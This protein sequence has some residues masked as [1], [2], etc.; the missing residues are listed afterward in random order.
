MSFKKQ[1]L[2]C[3]WAPL[4]LED[5]TMEHVAPVVIKSWVLS[6]LPS[7]MVM[8]THQNPLQDKVIK[9]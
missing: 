8:K 2:A 7:H 3:F 4:G 6:D 9:A 1:L 5:L